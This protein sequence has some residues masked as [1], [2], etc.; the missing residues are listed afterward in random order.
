MK[1][2]RRILVIC[3]I[4]ATLAFAVSCVEREI[5]R[6]NEDYDGMGHITKYETGDPLEMYLNDQTST[7]ISS[8]ASV[9]PLVGYFGE[10]VEIYSPQ[11]QDSS[12]AVIEGDIIRPVGVGKT[13]FTWQFGGVLITQELTVYNGARRVETLSVAGSEDGNYYVGKTYSLT[14]SNTS[15]CPVSEL[16]IE[17]TTPYEN[18]DSQSLVTLDESGNITIVGLGEFDVWVHSKTNAEDV[19]AKVSV[20]PAFSSVE[21]DSAVDSFFANAVE[22]DGVFTAEELA[23]VEKLSLSGFID[24]QSASVESVF[25]SLKT[26]EIRLGE[27]D[28]E[29]K[30]EVLDGKYAWKI[31]GRENVE[32][33]RSFTTNDCQEIKADFE[34]VTARNVDF[35]SAQN[36]VVTLAGVNSFLGH[37]S[38]SGE[39]SSA[40]KAN[41]LTLKLKGGSNSTFTGG[42]SG[43]GAVGGIGVYAL[44][45]LAIQGE[46]QTASLNVYGGT[47]GNALDGG[48]YTGGKGGT[49]IYCS[50][51]FSVSGSVNA[52]IYGGKGGKGGL[53]TTGNQGATGAKGNNESQGADS[54]YG[55][56]G[57]PGGKGYQGGKGGTGGTGGDCIVSV[58]YEVPFGDVTL[59]LVTGN[60]GDGGKGGR[61]GKGG[62]GGNGG[63]DDN[64]S[65]IGIGDMAGGNG[66]S[67]GPGGDG[68]FGGDGGVAGTPFN[69]T[70]VG[71]A[72][73]YITCIIHTGSSGYVGATGDVGTQGDRGA[74]GD[75]GAM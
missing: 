20:T 15:N 6:G 13:N 35:S 75:G 28:Y 2:L 23:S 8:V 41:L 40:I 44:D 29:S 55:Y 48:G 26:V 52:N 11:I 43:G 71:D 4:L 16:E 67:G 30:T 36:A 7:T 5:F 64:W 25:P 50:N 37:S 73:E 18:V 62:T 22:N 10:K 51:K 61:G 1:N 14:T 33:G 17:V 60:G 47:G 68:G 49:A 3:F 58:L 56:D 21:I 31:V 9:K 53:G 12:V 32:C 34:N 46:N 70:D 27:N 74:N 24:L 19:G 69:N 72:F 66:G 42:N 63:D 59:T 38:S 45:E 54:T 57:R 39:G 65:F